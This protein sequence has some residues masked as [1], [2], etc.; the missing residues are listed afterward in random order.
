MSYNKQGPGT[1][2]DWTCYSFNPISG[3]CGHKC[4]YCYM[5]AMWNRY[6]EQK[7]RLLKISYLI[8]NPPKPAKRIFTGSSTDMWGD[9]VPTQWIKKVLDFIEK[10]PDKI[11]QF[12]T[13]N[14]KRYGTF[15]IMRN[16]WYGTTVD[17][18][19]KTKDNM[20][21]LI[22]NTRS[23]FD[24]IRYISFE[25]L[26]HKPQLDIFMFE[27]IDWII[28]GA[29][30][31]KGAV[32]PEKVWVDHL[33]KIAQYFH[34]PVWVKDNFEYDKVIKEFPG[35]IPFKIGA[36]EDRSVTLKTLALDN[37]QLEGK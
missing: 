19:D 22:N 3:E 20:K 2:I 12:L 1:N 14:P 11:F 36:F 7:K 26:I 34:I 17:G 18:T 33:I 37:N 24:I 31:T 28:I 9:W 15:P 6:E 30:S 23:G 25:P 4:S 10:H 27:K 16:A 13:K 32:K 29:D 5:N 35:D 8:K 21:D